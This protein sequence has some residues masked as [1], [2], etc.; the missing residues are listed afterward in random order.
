MNEDL[1]LRINPKFSR[2]LI[3]FHQTN[4]N[5]NNNNNKNLWTHEGSFSSIEMICSF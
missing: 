2:T 4:I 1:T 3:L 5:N